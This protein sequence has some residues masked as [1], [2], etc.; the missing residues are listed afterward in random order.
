ME[1]ALSWVKLHFKLVLPFILTVV[2]G[3]S[4]YSIYAVNVFSVWTLGVIA[5]T[6]IVFAFCEFVNK[7]HF[8]G[9]VL[10]TMIIFF[11]LVNF[12]KL[13][14]GNDWGET[15]QKWFL[16]GAEQVDTRFEYL[17]AVLIS[18]I[19]FL[20]AVVY[21]FTNVMY[22]L[23]FLTLAAMIPCAL[24]VKVLSE[25][26]NV[27][28]CLI[29]LLN[30]AIFM[31]N[32]RYEL[33][34]NRRSVG[35]NASVI[36]ACMFTFV[37]L[38]VSAL[39]PKKAEAIYYDKFEELFMDSGFTIELDDDFT[40]FADFSG[41]ADS[42][43]NFSNRRMYSVFADEL[44]Y[45][46]RQNFDYY[47]FETDCWYGDDHYSKPY[48][49][50]F[51]WQNDRTGLSLDRL[52]AAIL[53]AQRYESG[54]T[55]RYGLE[56]LS[57]FDGFSDELKEMYVQSEDFGAVYYITPARAAGISVFSQSDRQQVYVTR[58]GVFR[59]R[60]SAHPKNA[61]YQ[62]QYFSEL[63]PRFMWFELGGA[64]FSDEESEKMLTELSEILE[65]NNDPLADVAEAYLDELYFAQGY[66]NATA[67]NSELISEEIAALAREIT[68]GCT[69]DREKA[70][71]LQ[72]YFF[73]NDFV[74]DLE[75]DAKD[76]SPEYFLFQSKRGSCS[77]FATAF[78]LM[79]RSVGLAARYTEGF[80]P[81]VSS[82]ENMFI[83]RDSCSHAYPEVF[84]QNIGWLTFEPTVTSPYSDV[85]VD[86]SRGAGFSVD[87]K[88]V[89][90]M[91]AVAGVILLC[92]LLVIA[93]YPVISEKLF[94]MRAGKAAP[95]ECAVMA[96]RRLSERQ[97]S[98]IIRNTFAYT[99]NELTTAFYELTG[100]DMGFI[101]RAVEKTSYGGE[102]A[103]FSAESII[104]V[105]LQ[106]VK[107]AKEYGKMKN[108]KGRKIN[109]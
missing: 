3:C 64:D 8:V 97:L 52:R 76:T 79:A 29:S 47:D 74:Y 6:L 84:I 13:I 7:N 58:S 82:T 2:L 96:Y 22:R 93:F 30:V 88:L 103:D 56:R 68:A 101:S 81:D 25:I 43:R 9:G 94:L 28:I 61:G 15:F 44:M 70:E 14:R 80:S 59:N 71:A 33:V 108:V 45:L 19:P 77:D 37:L 53:A 90:V 92:V 34:G 75:Y 60:D 41:G 99:P 50:D 85:I 12:F 1:R 57:G 95:A 55:Q 4:V 78:V 69:Y 89:Y 67:E 27:Y 66:K 20:G 109:G 18:L 10:L 102:F 31:V 5:V 105:Y 16:T 35:M 46:K 39:I 36:S 42:Y 17:L 32:S 26:D 65:N 83:I 98:G 104:D 24:C 107:A 23:S 40:R 91:C 62:I 48:F 49:T 51:E 54:F 21:Y 73:R 87:Y 38:V 11:L 72:S 86:D 106:A 63:K 100:F